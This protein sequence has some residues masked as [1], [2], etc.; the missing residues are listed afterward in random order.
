M[1]V[2]PL[3]VFRPLGVLGFLGAK[4]IPEKEDSRKVREA[5]KV[6]AFL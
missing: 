1:P 2:E 5:R 6:E 3:F 4:S